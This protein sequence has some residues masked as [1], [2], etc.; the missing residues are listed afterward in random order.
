MISGCPGVLSRAREACVGYRPPRV[1]N[2]T[3]R[4]LMPGGGG[5]KKTRADAIWA[6]TGETKNPNQPPS[7]TSALH[8]PERPGY[9]G[10]VPL[11]VR[12]VKVKGSS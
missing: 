2:L 7:R 1:P 4:D 8:K 10:A 12:R 11:A 6:V 5:R 9:R 3:R